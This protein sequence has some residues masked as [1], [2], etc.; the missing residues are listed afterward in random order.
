[1][2]NISDE[3]TGNNIVVWS[4]LTL[5]VILWGL[6]WPAMKVALHFIPPL[7]LG[8][9][10]FLSA[11]VCLF[12]L[13]SIKGQLTFPKRRDLPIILSVGGLQMLAFTALGLIAMQYTD[14]SRAALLAYTTPLWGIFC[15]WVI[16]REFPRKIQLLALFTGL[17]GIAIICS[18]YE[19]DWHKP[20]VVAGCVLLLIAAL[21]WSIVIIHVKNH[22][23]N[24]TPLA[25]APWQ[26]LFATIPMF[27][28]AMKFEGLPHLIHWSPSLLA[29]VFF[30]GPIAT[31][32]CFVISTS[33]GRKVSGFVMS[34]FT[35]GVP[36]IGVLASV[37]L[38]GTHI[39]YVFIFGLI[40]IIIGALMAIIFSL[41]ES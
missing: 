40:M 4:L 39:S 20:G 34:N 8:T 7:W 10:R 25:V 29:L 1:M 18:P 35:L 28:L 16:S 13:V 33:C 21:C 27:F 30:I 12:I 41:K 15:S 3:N 2:K 26:M 9:L 38:L 24:L 17:V 22:Q 6:S 32:V 36:V 31:S 37:A 5:M 14:V 19:M 11:G 23:W